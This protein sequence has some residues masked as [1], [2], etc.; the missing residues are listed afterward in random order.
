MAK[1]EIQIYRYMPI[2]VSRF[3]NDEDVTFLSLSEFGGYVY[4]LMRAWLEGSIPADDSRA[5]A[6]LKR[7]DSDAQAT[8]WQCIKT[9][10]VVHP[11]NSARL[12]NETQEKTRSWVHQQHVKHVV[13]GS[14]GGKK[15]ASNAQAML[16]QRSSKEKK[17]KVKKG[18]EKNIPPYSP[19][20]GDG[21]K[22]PETPKINFNFET[23]KWDNIENEDIA[24][25]ADAYP[26]CNVAVELMAMGQWLLANPHKRKYN[27]RRF[28]TG[29]LKSHQDKGGS[30]AGPSRQPTDQPISRVRAKPGKYAGVGIKITD[31]QTSATGAAESGAD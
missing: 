26:A 19:P 11:A 30:H 9:F 18:K 15:R 29:W 14:K 13:A 5:L 16:K 22:K 23:R 27:Y 28:I 3:I 21:E 17:G 10:F 24:G 6:L 2:D 1:G 7:Q 12:I 31:V 8:V 25:W 20:K 4:L